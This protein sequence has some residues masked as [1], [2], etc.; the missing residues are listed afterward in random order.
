MGTPVLMGL[1]KY[2]DAIK[3]CD[4]AI[5]IDPNNAAA[6]SNKAMALEDQGRTTEAIAAYD[7]ANELMQR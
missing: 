5:R 2:D 3:A 6:W 7:K 4:I 1:E